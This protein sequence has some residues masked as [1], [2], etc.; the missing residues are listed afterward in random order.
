MSFITD[1]QTLDD[2]NI[3]GK[4]NG[5]S[6]Y[7]IF[8]RTATRGGAEALE[9]MFQ[10]P[11]ST[12]A[13]INRRSELIRYFAAI[14]VTFPFNGGL[15]DAAEQYLSGT[16][17]RSK[18]TQEDNT[19]SRKLNNLLGADSAFKQVSEGVAATG[20]I[21]AILRDFV[22]SLGTADTPYSTEIKEINSILSEPDLARILPEAAAGK[23]SYERTAACDQ[24]L[25]YV[26][27]DKIRKLFYRIYH[28]DVYI[29]VAT[30]AAT[31][32]FVFPVALSNEEHV[33]RLEGV[34]HPQLDN[35]IANTLHITPTQNIVFLTGANMAG[36]S[37]F[38]KSLGIA[39]FLA[40]MGFP[41][42]AAHMEFSVRDGMY[43]TINLPDNLSMGYSHFYA[44][45]LR[46]KKVAAEL[47]RSKNLFVIFDELFRGTN[48]K[49]AYEATVAITAAFAQKRNSMFVIST[50][51]IEAGEV[52]KAQC[53]NINF[54]YLPTL[55]DGNKPVYTHKLVSGITADRHGMVIINNEGIIDILKSRVI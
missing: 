33:I 7:A 27:R 29:S 41:V 17:T 51:I 38:M 19:L 32:N 34:Y 9:H 35:P 25:R 31:R 5:H 18:L 24:V 22:Q 14:K 6:I 20:T 26:Y 2:L 21:L 52:L 55:M 15:F 8:N 42:A 37:T 12:V 43:T 47:G 13:E 30:V 4:R 45:V 1:K 49:D 50:H 44:E 40:H 10:C 11:L 39:V 53:D 3:F 36:K 54:S 16:D 23:L 48:V 46:L 28:L